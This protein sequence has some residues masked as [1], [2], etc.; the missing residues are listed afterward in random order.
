[1]NIGGLN[2]YILDSADTEDRAT[3]PA[4][5]ELFSSQLDALKDQLKTKP[6]WIVTHRPIWGLVPVARVGSL[7]PVEAALN[8]TEQTAVRG[9][10]LSAVTMV[11]SGHI[12]LFAS[13][14]FGPSR[15]AQL[16]AGTGGD[17]GETGEVKTLRTAHVDLDGQGADMTTFN[18]YGFLIL[19]RSGAD[20][21]GDFYDLD[22]KVVARCRLHARALTCTAVKP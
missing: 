7:P 22:D 21:A 10:D 3:P 8:L 6:G 17:I 16:I 14:N 18:R 20:W 19:D 15:P 4:A 12:H 1:M 11:V 2:L 5:V 9:H 13:F